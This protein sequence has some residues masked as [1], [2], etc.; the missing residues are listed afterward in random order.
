MPHVFPSQVIDLI[1]ECF[2][3]VVGEGFSVHA[4]HLPHISA[5]VK[6]ASQI[7][8]ECIRLSGQDYSNYVLGLEG[9]DK[10][11]VLWTTRGEVNVPQSLGGKHPLR[12]VRDALILC[13][14][15]P[16]GASTP[17]L[18]FITD[19]AL[20]ESVRADISASNSALH[21]GEWKA[22]TV[23]AGAATEALLL[24]AIQNSPGL[25]ALATKPSGPKPPNAPEHWGLHDYI[26]VAA[27]L[28]LIKA[29]TATQADLAKG[30]RN[31]IHPGKAQR[32][33]Q[34][35]TRGTALAAIASLE[36]VIDDLS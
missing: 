34:V 14:D 2:P 5:I 25:A 28:N 9:L 7:P 16:T 3:S 32:T 17:S 22:A 19:V 29:S 21:N 13:P 26:I 31:L 12:L 1:D 20:R 4:G 10:I 27:A 36:L 35:C 30:F 6:L 23:L 33:N 8:T 18:P 15:V 24:W 11:C